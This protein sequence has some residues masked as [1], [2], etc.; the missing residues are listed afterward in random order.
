LT[1]EVLYRDSGV[2][3]N[4]VKYQEV[5]KRTQMLFNVQRSRSPQFPSV[6]FATL[7]QQHYPCST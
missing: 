6:F 5:I 4:R 1:L 3:R 2:S 7:S